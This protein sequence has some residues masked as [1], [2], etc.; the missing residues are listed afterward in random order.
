MQM[1]PNEGRASIERAMKNQAG[2]VSGSRER[3]YCMARRTPTTDRHFSII[4]ARS[5]RTIMKILIALLGILVVPSGSV[6]ALPEIS[7]GEG[8]NAALFG[9]TGQVAALQGC[10]LFKRCGL[11]PTR[12]RSFMA[13][14]R[15]DLRFK[16]D[17]VNDLLK[18]MVVQ[19]LSGG[20]VS[21]VTYGSRDPIAKTLASFGINLTG[22]PS[23]GQMLDQIR[24]ERIEVTT[25]NTV[26]GI[27]VGVEKKEEAVGIV[28]DLR[29]PVVQ[30]EYLN[31]LTEDGLRSIPLAQIQRIKLLN[32]RLNQDLQ[33][34][35]SVLAAGHD[36]QKKAVSITFNGEGMRNV[37]VA[38]IIETPVWKTAY[39]L[40]LEDDR[41]TFLQG[42][43][44][45]ENSTEVDWSR[46][47]S[48]P[49]LGPSHFLHHGSLSAALCDP[50]GG[51]PG[52]VCLLTA[53]GIRRSPW[54][55]GRLRKVRPR[56]RETYGQRWEGGPGA[57]QGQTRN[58]ARQPGGRG[59]SLLPR[60][61]PRSVSKRV[62]CPTPK[63]MRP[64][65]CLNT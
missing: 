50:S 49:R 47:A 34:A 37:R 54:T 38:Y 3:L 26:I 57:G 62:S 17:Q 16:M 15:I 10:A 23:L 52:I 40:V 44:I 30:V 33:Q 43:A 5:R 58:H 45:V 19:D 51:D 28:E 24:G 18:S 55:N 1:T 2:I 56:G 63:G 21:T 32:D 60:L 25:P 27:I 14:A 64:A 9:R 6:L 7:K 8:S 46:G 53:T 59:P 4:C 35:L 11:F 22:N 41:P 31:V 36:T 61:K 13:S 29:R 65:S 12:R 39:R 42:W 48:V 20:Q